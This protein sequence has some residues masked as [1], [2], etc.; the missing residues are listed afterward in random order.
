[1]LNLIFCLL[2]LTSS[3]ECDTISQ[4]ASCLT[5]AWPKFRTEVVGKLIFIYCNDVLV[6]VL[7]VPV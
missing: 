1:M 7:P 5:E 2:M 3:P 6:A 4:P